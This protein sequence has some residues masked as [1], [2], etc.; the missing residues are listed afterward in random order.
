MDLLNPPRLDK[1][2]VKRAF[3]RSASDYDR[4]AVLQAEV[5]RRLIER[6]DY[7]KVEPQWVLDLGCGTGQ[8]ITAL[9][10]KYRSAKVV[11]LDLAE[12]MLHQASKQY[13]LFQRKR[14]INADLEKLPFQDDSFD[15]VF[16]SL[17]LQWSN[18]LRGAFRELKRVVRSGGVVMFSTLGVNSLHELRSSWSSIDP[19]PRVHQFMDMHD[20]GD[21]MLAAGL[22][23]PVVDMEEITMTYRDFDALMQDIKGIGA[24]NA[25]RNR[26]RG[27]MTPRRLKRL[28]EAYRELAFDESSA[29]Y[30][31]TYEVVYG[32]AWF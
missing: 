10:R 2:A 9:G 23:Q 30:R 19:S 28:R 4:C 6:L 16:S 25:E 3:N 24:S 1:K 7:L 14:L 15:L 13:R 32:H 18:D 27:L 5:Q 11:G 20:V 8:A 29:S 12:A 22:L 31:A 21:V 17:A 26:S